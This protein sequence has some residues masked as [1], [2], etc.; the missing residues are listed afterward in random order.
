[1]WDWRPQ[2][3]W[4]GVGTGCCSALGWWGQ[5]PCGWEGQGMV[6]VPRLLLRVSPLAQRAPGG[7]LVLLTGD[8]PF[9][10]TKALFW[11]GIAFFNLFCPDF[12]PHWGTVW[13]ERS[14]M[15]S[16]SHGRPLSCQPG[17]LE[18]FWTR[19][20]PAA[21]VEDPRADLEPSHSH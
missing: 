19:A 11:G 14:E 10:L 8:N 5:D 9:L 2:R 1:M 21:C 13:G 18:E 17:S 15:S 12:V 20:L 3:S 16:W 4:G 7:V 6:P